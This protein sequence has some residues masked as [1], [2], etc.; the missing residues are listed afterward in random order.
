MRPSTLLRRCSGWWMLLACIPWGV[1]SPA[2]EALRTW[3]SQDGKFSVE[4]KFVQL[5]GETALLEK[6]DGSRIPVP[7]SKLSNADVEYVRQRDSKPNAGRAS[8]GDVVRASEADH[9][10][11]VP[12]GWKAP[13][14]TVSRVELPPEAHNLRGVQQLISPD[15]SSMALVS[16]Q[17]LSSQGGGGRT[18]GKAYLTLF[19]LQSG[20]GPTQI[21]L[22]ACLPIG[23]SPSKRSILAL[24]QPR[25]G[26]FPTTM[27]VVD[28]EPSVKLRA[29]LNPYGQPV[30]LYAAFFIDD[31]HALF[32]NYNGELGLVHIDS[33][34][35]VWRLRTWPGVVPAVSADGQHVAVL[36]ADKLLVLESATGKIVGQAVA[37]PVGAGFLSMNDEGDQL[38][39]VSRGVVRVW[40]LQ[41]GRESKNFGVSSILLDPQN[42][43]W[44]DD[45]QLLVKS[46]SMVYELVDLRL[47]HSVCGYIEEA[48]LAWGMNTN[49]WMHGFAA[50][51][52]AAQVFSTAQF[53]PPNVD[54]SSGAMAVDIAA[55]DAV[56]ISLEAAAD[57][58]RSK[59]LAE[60]GALIEKA[61]YRVVE[62][63]GKAVFH[64]KLRPKKGKYDM[65]LED[66]PDA[67]FERRVELAIRD[68]DKI[69]WVASRD[70][71][72]INKANDWSAFVLPKVLKIP[73]EPLA[74]WKQM[75][76]GEYL[77][78]RLER[79]YSK[80]YREQAGFAF[81][82]RPGSGPGGPGPNPGPRGPGPVPPSRP[83]P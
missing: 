76:T 74:A 68:G 78:G 54:A 66:L 34:K 14:Q 24:N 18:S 5:A 77:P 2:Q 83:R 23:M 13:A 63:G 43:L 17:P 58:D 22:P 81:N 69:I 80:G 65:D 82:S 72:L 7:L 53:P 50:V 64:A 67:A 31:D 39:S 73:S 8:K 32:T 46:R 47:E 71:M 70:R 15:R 56:S 10:E 16:S 26:D 21:A 37:D 62:S 33:G 6:S 11:Y 57:Y 60:L 28:I 35:L 75:A 42:V 3:T 40:D 41:D 25:H 79:D 30:P 29:E 55:G 44:I 19:D 36:T 12:S 9:W 1:F 20:Q 38:A 27:F 61:G 59:E 48:S 49:V 4:A 51:P 52:S 45:S